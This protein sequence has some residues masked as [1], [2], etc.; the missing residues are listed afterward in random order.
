MILSR[1][2]EYAIRLIFYLYEKQPLPRYARI[3]DIAEELEISYNQLAKVAH[4]LISKEILVS[5]TGP[6]GGI[7]LGKK[8]DD[9]TLSSIIGNFGDGEIFDRCVLGL[10]ECSNENP[11]PIHA[12]WGDT[13]GDMKDIFFMKTLSEL[14]AE[15]VLPVLRGNE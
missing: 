7:D 4:V 11:C 6:K 5:S 12:V 13:R 9:L 3:K 8:A 2:S 15:A 10:S 14:K 1:A